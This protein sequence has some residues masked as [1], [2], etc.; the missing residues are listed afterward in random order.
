MNA[1]KKVK[2][3]ESKWRKKRERNKKQETIL[4]HKEKKNPGR[5]GNVSVEKSQAE[6]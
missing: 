5:E 4:M 6:K 2:E 3:R 1:K